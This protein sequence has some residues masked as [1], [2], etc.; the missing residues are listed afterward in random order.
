MIK[1]RS[2]DPTDAGL[3]DADEAVTE[4]FRAHYPAL[5]RLAL[6]LC[7]DASRAEELAQDAYVQLHARW[8][9]LRDADKALAYLRQSVVNRSRSA[10]RHR[11]VVSQYL[12]AQPPPAP[13]PS[14]EHGA[15]DLLAQASMIEALGGLP[16]RQREA[17][18]LRYYLDLSEADIAV[19]MGVSRGA[20]K[21]HTARGIAA[22]RQ[23]LGAAS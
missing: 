22:L 7:G 2:S 8:K 17:L 21:S 9:H 12:A 4:L 6:L 20:V 5:V 1:L 16:G 15:L 13:A 18:I 3:W 19:A 14:A 11:A 10:H 23:S